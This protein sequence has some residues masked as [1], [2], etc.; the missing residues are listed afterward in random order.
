MLTLTGLLPIFYDALDVVSR[1]LIGF[2]PAVSRDSSAARA[3]VGDVVQSPVVGT[4][5]AEDVTPSAYAA[6]PPAQTIDNVQ[7]TIQK[8]RGVPFGITGEGT[9]SLRNAG[10]FQQINRDRI[11]NAMRVLTNEMEADIAKLHIEASRAVGANNIVPFG[12]PGDFMDFANPNM[13]LDDNGSPTSDRHMVLGSTAIANIRGKQSGLF[14][15]NTSGTDEL[16]RRGIIGDVE[17]LSI[18]NSA[19]TMKNVT[20]GAGAGARTI[21]A[22]HAEEATTINLDT[23]GSGTILDGDIIT[24]AGDS[25]QYVVVSGTLDVSLGGMITIAEPGLQ[26]A[27]PA[28][29]T[30]ITVIPAATRN[31]FFH[32]SAIQLATRTPAM[33]EGGDSADD[34]IL[35]TDPVSGLTYEFLVYR[36]KRQVRY[37]VNIAWGVKMIAPRHCGLLIGA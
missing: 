6:T 5:P 3:A 17:G 28:V 14:N 31:M 2:I 9:L 4:M 29:A 24:F 8:S 37:E 32:R 27:I 35:I 36:Q 11:V 20:V 10:T 19:Q 12:T 13:V 26:Q 1:E 15:L 18:H 7:M 25:N 22:I 34:F 23:A 16:L 33:P 21:V 30:S